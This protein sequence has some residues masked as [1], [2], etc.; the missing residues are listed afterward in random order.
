M[1]VI[2]GLGVGACPLRQYLASG[3]VDVELDDPSPGL[4]Q[5]DFVNPAAFVVLKLDLEYLPRLVSRQSL[6]HP[7]QRQDLPSLN[8]LSSSFVVLPI[9]GPSVRG[10]QTDQKEDRDHGQTPWWWAVP[11]S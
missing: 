2:S 7:S 3:G 10:S 1:V 5:L 6:Q 8:R 9:T 4:Q 11:W